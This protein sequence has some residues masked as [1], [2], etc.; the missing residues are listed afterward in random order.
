MP[1][2]TPEPIATERALIRLEAQRK[3]LSE[4]VGGHLDHHRTQ[5]FFRYRRTFQ[6]V[7]GLVMVFNLVVL[8]MSIAGAFEPS[9]F[10]FAMIGFIF[11]MI[12]ASAWPYPPNECRC[13]Q[14]E[15]YV[16]RYYDDLRAKYRI[17]N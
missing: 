3:R 17:S 12:F 15:P 7:V 5:C 9:S 2:Q 8:V 16:S 6:L 14:C 11:A 13:H 1:H 10:L 4:V